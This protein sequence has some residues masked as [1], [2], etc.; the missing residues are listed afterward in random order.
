M[1]SA[2]FESRDP[3]RHNN[4]SLELYRYA[5]TQAR[6]AAR[7]AP[8]YLRLSHGDLCPNAALQLRS[9]TVDHVHLRMVSTRV[10]SVHRTTTFSEMSCACSVRTRIQFPSPNADD[11]ACDP[12]TVPDHTRVDDRVWKQ[13]G[14]EV[15]KQT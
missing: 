11:H 10:A 4:G 1:P 9:A 14:H 8:V 15:A 2:C 5:G 3:T 6:H 13:D 7:H 12:D